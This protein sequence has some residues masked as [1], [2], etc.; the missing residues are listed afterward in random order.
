MS[1]D[2]F[3]SAVTHT[4]SVSAQCIIYLA[5]AKVPI[6]HSM[7]ILL[8]ACFLHLFVKA[9]PHEFSEIVALVRAGR[10]SGPLP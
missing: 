10:A 6:A 4:K 1:T 2:I 8:R 3:I 7:N 9:C 5:P